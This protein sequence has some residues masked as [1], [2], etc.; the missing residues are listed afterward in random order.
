MRLFNVYDQLYRDRKSKKIPPKKKKK[1]QVD[2]VWKK[3]QQQQQQDVLYHILQ[4]DGG[5]G[6]MGETR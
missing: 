6:A 5:R 3:Q 1:E 4:T 2:V